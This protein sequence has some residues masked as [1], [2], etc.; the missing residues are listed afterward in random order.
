MP[1]KGKDIEA[2]KQKAIN[3][4]NSRIDEMG[5][6]AYTILL[7]AIE[8]TFDFKAGKIDPGKGFTKH[9]NKLTVD[10]LDLLQKTPKFTGPVSQFV[11]RMQ[12]ISEAISDFQKAVNGVKVPAFETAKNMVIDEVVDGLLDNGLNQNF[13]QPL[14]SLIYQN[15]TNG[16]SL[17][18]AREAIKEYIQGGKDV[19]GKL[20]KYIEQT[21]QQ[22]VDSYAGIINMKILENFDMDGLLIT[23]TLIDTSSPQCRYVI[24]E[25]N[26]RI[27]RENWPKVKAIAEK[28]GLIENT[29]FDNLPLLK[30]HWS[31]RHSF[32]PYLD[33]KKAA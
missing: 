5:S 6:A 13:V 22:A 3:L 17:K 10:V 15:V 1:N 14:R 26:G 32:F 4:L 29:T 8:D 19:T 18:D 16:L 21:A 31:C 9:L 2:A 7:A 25:L 30:L 20:G 28:Y 12:P 24:N 23:G 33:K 11:K 27:T